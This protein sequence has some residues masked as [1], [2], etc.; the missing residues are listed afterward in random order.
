[1]DIINENEKLKNSEKIIM[2]NI[3]SLMIDD[4]IKKPQQIYSSIDERIEVMKSHISRLKKA[5]STA[6]VY[7]GNIAREVTTALSAINSN[8]L[9]DNAGAFAGRHIIKVTLPTKNMADEIK[10]EILADYLSLLTESQSVPKWDKL[11]SD[12]VKH[13]LQSKQLNL[14]LLMVDEY[15][16]S[17]KMVKPSEHNLSDGQKLIFQVMM[18]ISLSNIRAKSHAISKRRKFQGFMVI[19]NPFGQNTNKETIVPKLE[20]GHAMGIQFIYTM[21]QENREM[22]NLFEKV[23]ILKRDRR[24]GNK[25]L[26]ETAHIEMSKEDGIGY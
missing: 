26:V 16:T 4:I 24:M 6:I 15:N 10:K 17:G 12:I 21:E 8:K 1:T 7:L 9:P 2:E 23:Y 22:F 14:R 3:K 13:L 20:L 18:Y 25:Q 19:D 5:E 11:C